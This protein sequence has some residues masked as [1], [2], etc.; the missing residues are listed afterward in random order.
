MMLLFRPEQ[1]W[2]G[3]N[4]DKWTKT[5]ETSNF[6][7]L[8]LSVNILAHLI[9][10]PEGSNFPPGCHLGVPR[11]EQIS[12]LCAFQSRIKPVSPRLYLCSLDFIW[13]WK[14]KRPLRQLP[15][16]LH[17]PLPHACDVDILFV[18][19]VSQ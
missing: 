14:Q 10:L 9:T 18:F 4:Q 17:G 13:T 3:W 16:Q 1:K 11:K 5:V 6:T 7:N 12:Y 2:L 8:H 15:L 19:G